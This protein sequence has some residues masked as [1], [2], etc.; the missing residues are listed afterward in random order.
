MLY[1]TDVLA[2]S[3]DGRPLGRVEAVKVRILLLSYRVL[4]RQNII[5]SISSVARWIKSGWF[6]DRLLLDDL[7][8]LTKLARSLRIQLILI[9]LGAHTIPRQL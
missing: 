4:N 6:S 3:R 7:G 2:R 9:K 5:G 1:H 8:L